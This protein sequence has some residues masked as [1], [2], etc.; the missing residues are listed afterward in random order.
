[1]RGL[2][3]ENQ[4]LSYREKLPMPEIKE[5]SALVKLRVGGICATDLEM[6]RGYY[7]FTGVPGHEF[8]GEVIQA[9]GAEEWIGRRVV[10]EINLTC[11]E[12][13]ACRAGREHHCINR[14]A[15]GISR[16]MAFLQ[17]TSPCPSGICMPFLI[18]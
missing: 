4:Q 11:G 15:L 1:M 8:V 16:R 13:A 18:P 7:P 5:G 3:L 14:T 12:C 9:P 6:T 10:G 2:W 17:I